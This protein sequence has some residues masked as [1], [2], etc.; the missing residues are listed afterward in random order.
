MKKPSPVDVLAAAE[1]TTE[2]ACRKG[3]VTKKIDI[4]SGG[5][6]DL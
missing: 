4:Q 2:A 1:K 3:L 6:K 5:K